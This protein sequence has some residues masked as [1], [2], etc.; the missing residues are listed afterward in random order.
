[1]SRQ[2][3]HPFWIS[4]ARGPLFAWHDVP[5]GAVR[6][7]AV[8]LCK[9]FGYDAQCT[10]R[11]YRHLARRL[12]DSG[13]HV[14]RI[15]YQGTGDSS[16]G[17]SDEGRLGALVGSVREGMR[18]IRGELGIEKIVLFGS[19]F[20]ALI[21]LEA[22]S[23][24]D[25]DAIVL[26]APPAS[27]KAWLREA[28]A[29]R[30]LINGNGNGKKSTAS[31][32]P[33]GPE[34]SAGFLLTASTIESLRQLDPLAVERTANA[35]LI[36]ARDDLPGSE[37]RLA[38][39]LGARGAEVTLSRAPGYGAMMQPDPHK[40][41]VPELAWGEIT[42]W[43]A[44]RFAAA[45]P[46]HGEGVNYA[47][48]ASVRENDTVVPVREEAVDVGG[49]FGILTEPL[50]S[51]SGHDLPT[52]LLHNTGVNSH[53]GANRMNVAL[54]RRWAALGFPVLRFDTAGLGDS[55]PNDLVAENRVYSNEAPG[56]SRRA[57]DFL[58][59]ARG[60]QRF[61]LLGIC[62]GAYVS[63]HSAIADERVAGIILLNILLFHWKEGDS[64]DVRKRDVLKSTRF[65][66]RAVFE[67]D[68]WMRLL[69]GDV[70]VGTI[71]H[72]LLQKG[73]ERARHRVAHAVSGE[74]DVARGFRALIRRGTDVLLVFGADDGGRDVID[75]HLGTNAERFRGETGFRLEV[76]DGTDHTFSPL[77][78][79]E[80]LVTLLTSHLLSRFA[81]DMAPS[82]FV[83]TALAMRAD[84]TV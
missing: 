73:W 74:S 36:V 14:L 65:Y 29:L 33:E 38:S 55:P 4:T 12:S 15:D 58:A 83:R 9:P 21:A 77:S 37:E 45:R 44:A 78:S 20:G 49:L 32:T 62:S 41:I 79:Q 63:F 34:E 81:S 16:G 64:V 5:A 3:A 27:G 39:A 53:I 8:V 51:V 6:D 80:L 46:V 75:E 48:H 52:I 69:R 76:L 10:Q 57:M 22:A 19:R 70:A 25:V 60:T 50:R 67:R 11:A 23:Q 47:R 18:W 82:S 7:A 26:L 61:V 71:A 30:A 68:A 43:L 59:R 54:A 66:S 72:G 84:A 31:E 56:D 13:F 24:G 35:V 17:D 28:R 2:G 42:S 40:S 1:M